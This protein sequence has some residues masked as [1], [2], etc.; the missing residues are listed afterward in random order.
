M[1]LY[2]QIQNRTNMKSKIYGFSSFQNCVIEIPYNSELDERVS[3]QEEGFLLGRYDPYYVTHISH[4]EISKYRPNWINETRSAEVEI[5]N[6]QYLTFARTWHEQRRSNYLFFDLVANAPRQLRK[7]SPD[8]ITP[9]EVHQ[10][11]ALLKH[12][13]QVV[14]EEN[15]RNH[16]NATSELQLTCGDLGTAYQLA[17]QG[18]QLPRQH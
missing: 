2:F 3:K 5:T 6:E 7:R 11:T 13:N 1:F 10:T 14:E 4:L 18:L 15:V 9:R 12:Q 8:T 17:K 16:L